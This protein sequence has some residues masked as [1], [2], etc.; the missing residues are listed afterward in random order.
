[1][2]GPFRANRALLLDEVDI[3]QFIADNGKELECDIYIHPGKHLLFL[4]TKHFVYQKN[5]PLREMFD[6]YLQK[7]KQNGIN[8]LLVKKY[9]TPLGQDCM[10]PLVK[11]IGHTDT[12]FI[13]VVCA[14]GMGISLVVMFIEICLRFCVDKTGLRDLN[15]AES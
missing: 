3:K 11:E 9:F 6:H 12:I 13:F 15:F 5:F 14:S 10:T 2:L 7:I 1:M 4:S 8:K